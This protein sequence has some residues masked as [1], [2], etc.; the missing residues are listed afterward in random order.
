MT[1]RFSSVLIANRGEIACRIIRTARAEGYRTIALYTDADAKSPHRELADAS[2][3]IG[4]GPVSD[5]YLNVPRILEAAAETGADAIHPGYGFLSE[6]AGFAEACASAGLVF[7]GPSPD[8][9]RLMGNKAEA[10]KR[11][12]A[13]GVSCIPGYQG[14]NQSIGS[15]TAEAN[16][17]G[18]PVM[19]KAAA[20]GGG[21]GM[22]L[23]HSAADLVAAIASARSEAAQAFGSAELILEKAIERPRHVEIQVFADEHGATINLG[24]RDCS[25][26]RRHQ[27]VIEEAPCPVMTSELRAAMGEAAVMAARSISYCGAGTVEF[28]LDSDGEFYF[29]EMNTRLQVEHPVTELV[30]GLD[31]VSLQ[32]KVAQGEPL[33]IGQ[34]DVELTGH[35]IEARLYA[36]DVAGGFLPTSGSILQWDPPVSDGIRVDAGIRSG[37]DVSPYYDPMLAK[38]IA[39]GADREQARSRLEDALKNLVLFGVKS[40]R[41]FL[42]D[43]LANAQFL[44]GNYS[45]AFIESEFSDVP[46]EARVPDIRAAAIAAVLD[47]AN[48]TRIARTR[49]LCVAPELLGWSSAGALTSYRHYEFGDCNY[50]LSISCHK[51]SV[52]CESYRVSESDQ[53]LT[54]SVTEFGNGHA[55]VVVDNDVLSVRYLVQ[56]AGQI[57]MQCDGVSHYL[58]DSQ[59]ETATTGPEQHGG[60][61]TAPMHGMISTVSVEV[62]ETVVSGQPLLR[63]E[64][65]K[66]QHDVVATIDGT[67]TAAHVVTGAQVATDDLLVEISEV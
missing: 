66:M 15:L 39:H 64:A 33:G 35:A 3:R 31:L 6:N 27:K 54:L 56:D 62:G 5:S 20:G 40:N 61:V 25:V 45:T 9:I 51:T 13:A 49:A 38:V 7:I 24:E 36:E 16:I 26:Q 60:R 18:F 2:F 65:M 17:I 29:L 50:E 55:Q 8:A 53:T 46:V 43:C 41:E 12:L 37:T 34:S 30:T 22:R 21:R 52:A 57:Y 28:L 32:L 1:K 23:V 47:I 58:V 67:V 59:S 42:I 4:T 19:I 10:K 11:M 14:K 63:M 48:E 44:S